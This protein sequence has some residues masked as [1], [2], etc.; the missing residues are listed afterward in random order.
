MEKSLKQ[1][2]Q[3]RS[4]AESKAFVVS[5]IDAYIELGLCIECA[6]MLVARDHKLDPV[7]VEALWFGP[8][9]PT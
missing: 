4:P 8:S 2:D 1:R 3:Q 5:K 7:K 9:W 6:F